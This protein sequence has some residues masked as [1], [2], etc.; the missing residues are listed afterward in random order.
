MGSDTIFIKDLEVRNIIGVDSWERSKRQPLR[1]SISI[2]SDVKDAG[3]HDSLTSSIN[4]GTVTKVVQ[5]FSERTEYRS[6][7]ALAGGI[8]KVVIDKCGAERVKVR[9]EKPRALLHAACAGVELVRSKSDIEALDAASKGTTSDDGNSQQL[10]VT[11]EDL[12]FVNDLTVSTIIGVNAWEREEKQRV[13]MTLIVHLSFQPYNIIADK[14]PKI[15]DYR[16]L[17]RLVLK[18]VEASKYKTVEALATAV[19]RIG[20][21]ECHVPKITVRVEKPSALVFASASG[22]E[23]TR[24]R[25]DFGL[26]SD[27]TR[28]GTPGEDDADEQPTSNYIVSSSSSPAG[29][30]GVIQH[31]GSL[32]AASSPSLRRVDLVHEV[33]I[34]LGTNLGERLNNLNHALEALSKHS[35]IQLV[36]TSFLYETEPMYVTDQPRF[37]NM[38]CKVRT[39]LQPIPLLDVLKTIEDQLGRLP[40]IRNG[41]RLIDL[42]II[43]YDSIELK[44]ERLVIPHPRIQERG[45]V[46]KPLCDIAAE[47]EHPILYRS[48]KQMLALLSHAEIPQDPIKRILP[49]PSSPSSPSS[50]ELIWYWKSKTFIMGILN[51]TPD[52]FSDGGIDSNISNTSSLES[53]LE[54]AASMITQGVDIIDIGGMSTR[55]GSD[56]ISLEEELARTIPVIKAI[57]ARH[58]T[59]PISIDTYRSQVALA[60]IEAGANMVNDV[61]GG[62]LDS[63]MLHVVA[64]LNVPYIL[65]HMRGTPKTMSSMTKYDNNDV[66]AA[67]RTDIS[68]KVTRAIKYGIYRWNII[69]DPGIGFAKD[70]AG[71][72]DLIRRLPEFSTGVLVNFPVLVGPSRKGFIGVATGVTDPKLRG[73]GTAAAC[74]AAIAGGCDLLR[75]HDV[76]EMKDAAQVS[77][78]IWRSS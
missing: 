50:P 73:F 74:T 28:P 64:T 71:N 53:T 39:S 49:I 5:E 57:R 7:E 48:N 56:P 14:V 13:V 65:M 24:D 68:S 19:A 8:A 67:V 16:T 47:M 2:Y 32:S 29:A 58:P 22:V 25:G 21:E 70:S 60:A 27:G 6:V 40:T 43:Y 15:H 36:D 62:T 76:K 26:N 61:S 72:F 52:S 12:I 9:V 17:S 33:Y 78:R 46:L 37:L 75:V 45:F 23:I 30:A 77:D 66:V 31:A 69:V 44:S 1:I 11:G 4:Y 59:T 63:E 55:P 42:D 18:H 41:P 20:I 35:E 10:D 54:R 34:A 51:V 3:T 38:A